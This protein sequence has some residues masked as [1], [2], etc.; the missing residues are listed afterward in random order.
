M[1]SSGVEFEILMIQVNFEYLFFTI[2]MSAYTYK[3]LLSR[4]LVGYC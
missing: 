4:E 3:D 1:P 2:A